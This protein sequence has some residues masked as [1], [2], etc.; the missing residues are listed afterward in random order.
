MNDLREKLEQKITSK[1]GSIMLPTTITGKLET[2]WFAF[3]RFCP[4]ELGTS[5]LLWGASQS[6]KSL[7]M[8]KLGASVQEKDGLFVCFNTEAANRDSNHLSKVVPNLKYK[9]ILFYQPDYIEHTIES[10]HEIVDMTPV[11][12][13]PVFI[14]IDSINSCATKREMESEEFVVKDMSGAEIA[15][16]WSKALRQ[17]TNK[18]S[19]KPVVLC[20]VSQT[21]T[22]GIGGFRTKEVSGGGAAPYFYASTV[23]K[24]GGN[25]FLYKNSSDGTYKAKPK[26]P[27]Q[28]K[29]AQECTLSLQKSRYSSGGS[30]L[31]YTIDFDTG[32]DSGEGL[33]DI[34][35]YHGIIEQT[36]GGHY[37]YGGERLDQGKINVRNLIMSTPKLRKE[38]LKKLG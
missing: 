23:V 2:G 33:V 29:S 18:M 35:V 4:V 8:M 5:M 12:S 31:G 36:G 34:L 16:I 6:G 25:K 9:D 7:I 22:G 37:T 30:T 13:A 38:L 1:F 19:K 14:S 26:H 21:R 10:I 27:L 3:D 32:I 24:T 17:L 11:D 20:L 15:S 28:E